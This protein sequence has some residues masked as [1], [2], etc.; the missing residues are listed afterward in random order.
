L[1]YA[2]LTGVNLNNARF[3]SANLERAT[4]AQASLREAYFISANLSNADLKSADLFNADFREANLTNADLRGVKGLTV[5][6]IQ[7]SQNWQYAIYDE[8]FQKKLMKTVLSQA[9]FDDRTVG[10]ICNYPD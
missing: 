3:C 2:N 10:H 5:E 6:Q 8:D 7:A 1:P 9:E 4:L